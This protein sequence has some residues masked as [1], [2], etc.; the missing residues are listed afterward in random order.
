[1]LYFTVKFSLDA[2]LVLVL[3][4]RKQLLHPHNDN[5]NEAMTNISNKFNVISNSSVKIY[6]NVN[7][8]FFPLEWLFIHLIQ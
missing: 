5:I 8:V 2:N 7:A 6:D 1:M 4:L 3:A